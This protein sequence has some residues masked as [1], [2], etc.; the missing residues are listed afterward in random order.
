MEK[1][2]GGVLSGIPPSGLALTLTRSTIRMDHAPS[3]WIDK[4]N[5][6]H[7]LV[8]AL[9]GA[10]DY[11]IDE[12]EVFRLSVGEAMLIP[13]GTRFRGRHAEGEAYRGVAQHFTLDLFGRDLVAR[14][15]LRP[16]LRFQDW[17]LLRPMIRRYHEIAPPSSTTLAQHHLFMVL[18]LAFLEE[19]FLG[20]RAD[21]APIGDDNRVS[22]AAAIAATQ[23]AAD[24]L[25]PQI[26][27]RVVASAPY[28]PDYFRRE[29]RRQTGFT[30]RKFQEFKRM[31]RAM[32]L[33]EAGRGVG[34]AGAAVG[35]ADPYYFSRM[36]RRYIGVS[37][38]GFKE[39]VRRRREGRFPHG[40]EDGQPFFPLPRP[41]R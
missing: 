2:E 25:D 38:L 28:N 15:R 20:W 17:D 26:A 12:G 33:L 3:W 10:G 1:T 35:Y 24:P 36:F 40:E 37:P 23:I 16:K 8:I 7:D 22:A 29:F 11:R 41:P 4:S 9:E 13:A 31:E 6:V 27:R 30:P 32:A 39:S 14:M 5:S 18:L 21:E 19:A 34:E